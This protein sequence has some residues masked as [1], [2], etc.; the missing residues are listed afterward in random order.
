MPA[1]AVIPACSF[2]GPS[3]A[4]YIALSNAWFSKGTLEDVS[5]QCEANYHGLDISQSMCVCVVGFHNS[6]IIHALE[7]GGLFMPALAQ[8]A[9]D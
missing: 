7:I 3:A 1:V 4:V 6:L 9:G 8:P 2:T 5:L